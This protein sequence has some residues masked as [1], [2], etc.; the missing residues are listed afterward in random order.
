MRHGT[1]NPLILLA[2]NQISTPWVTGSNPVG[3]A[4][5]FKWIAAYSRQL[6]SSGDGDPKVPKKPFPWSRENVLK[7][8]TGIRMAL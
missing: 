7:Q 4:N 1:S 8:T 2:P 5:V 3:I 6:M